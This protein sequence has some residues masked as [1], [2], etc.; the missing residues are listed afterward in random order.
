MAGARWFEPPMLES[1]ALSGNV[2]AHPERRSFPVLRR[3]GR[4]RTGHLPHGRLLGRWP[5]GLDAREASRYGRHRRGRD[6]AIPAPHEQSRRFVGA[7]HVLHAGP[8]GLPEHAEPRPRPRAGGR[9]LHQAHE[10][11]SHDR[12]SPQRAGP[13]ALLLREVRSGGASA[14]RCAIR[15]HANGSVGAGAIPGPARRDV[16]ADEACKGEG[17]RTLCL[18]TRPR[19]DSWHC[20]GGTQRRSGVRGPSW[21]PAAWT[22]MLA[23]RV[24]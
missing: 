22:T 5:Q 3:A 2:I 1:W 21:P 11:R 23:Q 4:S 12:G 15:R 7:A 13:R 24:A 8:G 18:R 10:S 16:P 14:R 19:T 20:M 9:H 6:R 17:G